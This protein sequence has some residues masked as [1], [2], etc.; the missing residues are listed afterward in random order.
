MRA[1]LAIIM[2]A[3]LVNRAG[4]VR[5]FV[6][7]HVPEDI[8]CPSAVAAIIELFARNKYLWGNVDVRPCSIPCNLYTV[9]DC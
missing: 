1:D 6:V 4:S 3:G 5:S 2:T 8:E 9:R 7:V